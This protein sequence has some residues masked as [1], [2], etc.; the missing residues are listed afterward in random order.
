MLQEFIGYLY[1]AMSLRQNRLNKKLPPFLKTEYLLALM[2][3]TGTSKFVMIF[4]SNLQGKN[5]LILQKP[6]LFSVSDITKI[7]VPECG[8]LL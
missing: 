7:I 5:F 1:C 8:Y 6:R 2:C 4:V 3:F